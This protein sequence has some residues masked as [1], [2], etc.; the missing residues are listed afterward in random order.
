MPPWKNVAG[1]PSN[2]KLPDFEIL[3]FALPNH[4]LHFNWLLGKTIPKLLVTY[5][6]KSVWRTP[7]MPW[8]YFCY[9][10]YYCKECSILS[11]LV[12][13]CSLH[14]IFEWDSTNVRMYVSKFE[15]D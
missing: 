5:G 9:G 13:E 4:F 10:Q 15:L 12:L 3:F 14:A 2:L 6:M 7:I 11:L 8:Y 1:H